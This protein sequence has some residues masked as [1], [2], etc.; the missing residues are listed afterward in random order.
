MNENA[1]K[2]TPHYWRNI[3]LFALVA[4]L[5]GYLFLQYGAYP[6]LLAKAHAHPPHQPICCETPADYDLDFEEVSLKTADGLTLTGW[7]VPS[8][9]GAALLLLH[10][11]GS[12][13]VMML[14]LG[15]GLAQAGYG[16]LLLD[17]RGHGTSEG[18]VVP[19]GGPEAEDVHAA[20]A[21]L[22]TRPEV[23]PNKIG[24]LGWSLGAQVAIMGATGNSDLKAVVADGPGATALADWPPPETLDELLYAPFDLMYYQFLPHQTGV[25]DPQALVDVLPLMGERPLLL[26]SSGDEIEQHRLEYFMEYATEPKEL[27]LISEAGHIGGWKVDSEAYEA[28]VIQFFEQALN[29]P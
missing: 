26:I 22:Q 12:T 1:K 18:D 20:V 28:R 5:V 17:L 4:S 29:Q 10:G 19:F 23:D 8:K 2:R 13:R 14:D 24:A 11:I 16:V 3:L 15:D 7:Y 27:W 25:D 21:Y 6:Y 9:N